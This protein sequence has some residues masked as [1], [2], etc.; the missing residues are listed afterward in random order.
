MSSTAP[1]RDEP[2][3]TLLART[4]R[5]LPGLFNDRIDLLSLELH[6]A[7]S[8]L[9][10]MLAFAAAGALLGI[11]AWIAFWGVITGL[12]LEAGW[13]WAAAP[14]LVLLVNVAAAAFALWKA[15]SLLRL[16]SLPA[17][18]R[19]LRFGSAEAAAPSPPSEGSP[20]G[21]APAAG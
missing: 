13:H 9:L 12:L 5:S 14:A 2:L 19:H 1:P 4:V 18:R 8:A 21:S 7:G 3:T 15:R 10:R 16:L 11:T 20:H 6:R 17:T